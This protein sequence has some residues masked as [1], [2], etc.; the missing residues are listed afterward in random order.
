MY[1]FFY[2][3]Y[4]ETATEMFFYVETATKRKQNDSI[5]KSY[6]FNETVCW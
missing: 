1:F 2:F 6:D 3:F 4:K 5:F